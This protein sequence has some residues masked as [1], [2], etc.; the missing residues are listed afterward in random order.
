MPGRRHPRTL[1]VQ[2]YAIYVG[3]I[4]PNKNPDV[5]ARALKILESRGQRLNVYHVGSD[6]RS[7]L[8]GALM[9]AGV[10]QPVQ[11]INRATKS[12]HAG[13][14]VST[15]ELPDHNIDT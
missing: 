13:R 15:R 3:N 7:L 4:S 8:A 6:D 14:D 2:P 10:I 12:R 11:T 9:A 5:L 1:L